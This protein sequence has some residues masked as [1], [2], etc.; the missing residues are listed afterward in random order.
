MNKGMSPFIEKRDRWGNPFALWVV[1]GM[2]FVLP[3]SFWGLLSVQTRNES[4]KWIPDRLPEQQTAKWY[5]RHFPLDDI[6]LVTWDGSSLADPRTDRLVEKIRGKADATGRHRGRSKLIDRVVSPHELVAKMGQC[7]LSRDAAVERLAGVVVGAGPLR[8]QLTDSGRARRDKVIEL[9]RDSARQSLGI[10]VDVARAESS[11]S[12]FATEQSPLEPGGGATTREGSLI[13]TGN[14]ASS[15]AAGAANAADDFLAGESC[16]LP[17]HDLTVTWRGMHWDAAKKAALIELLAQLRLPSTRSG[18]PSPGVVEKCFQLPGSP[19]A[20]VV[21]LSEAGSADRS[22]TVRELVA[23]AG[24]VG[25]APETIHVAGKPIVSAALDDAFANPACVGNLV[26]P[27]I[28]GRPGILLTGLAG[29]VVAFWLLRS[30]RLTAAVLSVSCFTTLVTTALVPVTNGAIDLVLMIIP[31]L[32]FVTSLATAI[33][34]ANCWQ[35]AATNEEANPVAA[36]MKIAWVPCLVTGLVI[37]LGGASLLASSLA[38]IRQFGLYASLGTLISLPVNLYALPALLKLWGGRP[39]ASREHT[40][41][42]WHALAARI[43]RRHASISA[44]ALVAMAIGAWGLASFQ[45]DSRTIRHFSGDSRTIKDY[46]FIEDK[47]AGVLPVDVIVRFDR[48]SQQQLKFLQRSSLVGMIENE[49]KKLPDISGALSLADFL[50][51]MAAPGDHANMREK[52]KFNAASR[53]IETRVKGEKQAAARPLLAV[54]DDASEFNAEGDELWRVTAQVAMMLPGDY[55]DLRKRIDD[56][57]CATLRGTSGNTADKVPPVG[58]NRNYHPGAS[59]IIAGDVPISIATQA[60]L[61]RS[62]FRSL[63]IAVAG[64]TLIAMVLLRNAAAGLLAM[65]PNLL[66]V[67]AVFGLTSWCGLPLDIGSAIA[68]PVALA[69]VTDGTLRLACRFRVGLQEQKGRTRALGVALAQCGPTVWQTTFVIV[70]GLSMLC[71]SE[72]V[73][74]SR[75]G[76]LTAVLLLT[77]CVSNFVLTPALLAGPLGR[78]IEQC[79]RVERQD[80]EAPS[81]AHD[82]ATAPQLPVEVVPGKPHVGKKG[83]RIRR[84]D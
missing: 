20:L 1:V 34:V 77:A 49:M 62:F 48:E 40:G 66:A 9:I 35:Q 43:T 41:R 28:Q 27:Q 19:I 4:Q 84:V 50:P 65:V 56:I 5:S 25:I 14:T 61:R 52:A 24:E 46:E 26:L 23:A 42:F 73:L 2:F 15:D 59:H 31:T 67:A 71:A 30:I 7:D 45:T 75:F 18:D 12:T 76:W 33:F 81:P 47:L 39:L 22:A 37:A 80:D 32:I 58:R 16:M 82:Q 54:A 6:V 70:S 53:T 63:A 72:M 13:D 38:P 10:E 21:Y 64:M 29:V 55:G 74:I 44:L 79:G 51:A 17:P 68:A 57:C 78:I 3:I 36:A 83:V 69:I 8:V 60:E 11:P